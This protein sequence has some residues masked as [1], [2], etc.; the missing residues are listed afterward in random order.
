MAVEQVGSTVVAAG[1][2]GALGAAAT[3]T[4]EEATHP[5]TSFTVRVYVF[6]KTLLKVTEAWK[7]TPSI[8]YVYWAP[9]GAVTVIDPVAV[10]QVGSTTVVVGTAGVLGAAATVTLEEAAHPLTSFTVSV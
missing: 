6:E 7:F 3:V 8:E 5:L 1:T 4:L 2:V 10:E 9:S